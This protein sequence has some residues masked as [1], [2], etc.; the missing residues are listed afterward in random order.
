VILRKAAPLRIHTAP[1]NPP[2]PI[3]DARK[4]LATALV[5]DRRDVPLDRSPDGLP[6]GHVAV[7]RSERL[8]DADA[9]I[10]DRHD[11]P[12]RRRSGLVALGGDEPAGGRASMLDHVQP[13]LTGG[14]E[15]LIHHLVVGAALEP[16]PDERGQAIAAVGVVEP[17]ELDQ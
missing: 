7:S 10:P 11:D 13:K 1:P 15:E 6:I 5:L 4:P 9:H 8:P 12:L 3:D 14:L 2:D 17:V 16:L